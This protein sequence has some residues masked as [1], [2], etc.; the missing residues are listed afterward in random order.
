MADI[1]QA[2]EAEIPC[3]QR[4]ALKLTRDAQLAED[5]VQESLVRGLDK[6]HL[7]QEGTNLRAWLCTILHNQYVNQIRRSVRERS[8]AELSKISGSLT[9]P[10]SQDKGLELRDLNRAL[11][12]LPATQRTAVLL[13]GLDGLRYDKAAEVVGVRVGTIR[14]RLSRG[15]EKLRMA[16]CGPV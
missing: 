1:S 16:A 10:P 13:I 5:L 12:K 11:K 14:S 7:W 8:I 4:Y 2:F 6:Q 3:L 15:R 9:R